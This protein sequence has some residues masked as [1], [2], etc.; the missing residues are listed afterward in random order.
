MRNSIEI[1]KVSDLESLEIK[2]PTLS[3]LTQ[4]QSISSLKFF[5][6]VFAGAPLHVMVEIVALDFNNLP[7]IDIE[8][9]AGKK[10]MDNVAKIQFLVKR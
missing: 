6:I 8:I 4:R 7:A 3:D 1:Q 2:I 5:E 9:K 10:K